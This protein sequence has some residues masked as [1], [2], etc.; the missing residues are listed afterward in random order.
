MQILCSLECL[1]QLLME[2]IMRLHIQQLHEIKWNLPCQKH[3]FSTPSLISQDWTE[4]YSGEDFKD[5]ILATFTLWLHLWQ[6]NVMRVWIDV[7]F[8]LPSHI[9][10]TAIFAFAMSLVSVFTCIKEPS[11]CTGGYRRRGMLALQ[12]RDMP[13]IVMEFFTSHEL[14]THKCHV[15]VK[16]TVKRMDD[17]FLS[18]IKQRFHLWAQPWAMVY[19]TDPWMP[20]EGQNFS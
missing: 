16:N 19:E 7:T 14:W 5:Q 10:P 15:A 11:E 6:K 8:G 18:R 3:F 17:E 4:V 12:Q 1:S 13:A 2:F 20:S 9:L